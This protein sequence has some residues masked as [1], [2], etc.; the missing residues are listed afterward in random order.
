MEHPA[1]SN[2]VYCS[3]DQV[4]TGGKRQMYLLTSMDGGLTWPTMVSVSPATTTTNNTCFNLAPSDP[5]V[6][7]M[8]GKE[9][10]YT[11]IYQTTD[12]VLWNEVTNN[13][14]GLLGYFDN[15]NAIWVAPEDPLTV[16]I[17]TTKGVF[18]TT[19]GGGQWNATT[20][21]MLTNDLL[22]CPYIDTLYAATDYGVVATTDQGG[23][24]APFGAGLSESEVNR[25]AVDSY[26]GFLY[27]GTDGGST[28]R[29]K[30]DIP[31][32]AYI[33]ELSAATG[34]SV[35]FAINAGV[36]KAGRKYVLCG[37]VTGTEP[38]TLLPGGK[39]LPLN[40]DIFTY[41]FVFPL[42]NTAV[43][44]NFM[45]TLDANGQA[46]AQLNVPPIPGYS[47]ITMYYAYCLKGPYNYVSNPVDIQI[48]D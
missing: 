1:D 6:M 17:G 3:G 44:S 10:L 39:I 19:D 29:C 32:A 47:G 14:S 31:L 27:A 21:T 7:Y 2:I 45:G 34:G 38:G 30:F 9:G 36:A 41:Y 28:W 43:F 8:A 48:V 37:G 5:L 18:K 42:I 4:G 23:S 15:I 35:D 25:L 20:L 40:L 12:G 16:L 24:W 46:L 13:L 26:H 22:Y 11:V 33:D